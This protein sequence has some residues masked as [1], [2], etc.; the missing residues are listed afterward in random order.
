MRVTLLASAAFAVPALQALIEGGHE[1]LVGTQPAR[2][3]GRGRKDARPTPVA[4]HCLGLGLP[5]QELPDVN[6]S[7]G[8]D[9]LSAGQPDLVVVVAFGQKLSAAV[10]SAAPWGC[11]NI[12]PSLLPRWRGA[13]PVPAAVLAGDETTGVC[14]IDV[15]ER[16]D[17]GQLLASQTLAVGRK[18]AGQ[19]L[20]ELS[21]LGARLLL[22][23]I[24]ALARD[25]VERRTQDEAAVTR[26]AKLSSDD[27]RVRWEHDAVQVDR[28][29]RAVTPAPGA[30]ALLDGGKRLRIL[31]GEPTS[32][33]RGPLPGEVVRADGDGLVVACGKD[34]YRI[35]QLQ[36][37]GGRPM[38]VSDF[39]RGLPLP[40][41]T[42]LGP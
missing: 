13:A 5:A 36:R 34:A 18:T 27:G 33:G 25:G 11:I 15:V 16:M 21:L 38:Q 41:G 39:L 7:E 19:L 17:A 22:E 14:V 42:R 10:R 35:T 32:W 37:E 3:A 20:D 24:D 28:R 9:W 8:L 12:H 26:A 1:V 40:A 31:Q 6:A 4:E 23:V 29:V 2:P 30:F